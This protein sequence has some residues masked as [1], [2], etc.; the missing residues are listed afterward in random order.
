MSL[1]HVLR[2]IRAHSMSKSSVPYCGTQCWLSADYKLVQHCTSCG[3]QCWLQASAALYESIEDGKKWLMRT[4]LQHAREMVRGF[5]EFAEQNWSTDVEAFQ[6]P[7][8]VE[9]GG[10]S[11]QALSVLSES[12]NNWHTVLLSC[13]LDLQ[14]QIERV[15]NTNAQCDTSKRKW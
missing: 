9:N 10:Q 3:T 12:Q 7:V 13:I 15:T 2:Q 5:L 14:V 6:G 1:W 8:V 11:N 4:N